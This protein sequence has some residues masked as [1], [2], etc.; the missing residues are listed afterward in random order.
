MRRTQSVT[1]TGAQAVPGPV[2]RVEEAC[3]R[4]PGRWL[5]PGPPLADPPLR[6]LSLQTAYLARLERWCQRR[7][8][9]LRH[10]ALVRRQAVQVA[11]RTRAAGSGQQ[12]SAC[13]AFVFALRAV[14]CGHL[15]D[16]GWRSA[17]RTHLPTTLHAAAGCGHPKDSC[18]AFSSSAHARASCRQSRQ[19]VRL[20]H[21]PALGRSQRQVFEF[22][23]RD[24]VKYHC[25]AP[26]A[27]EAACTR[28]SL[29]A[30]PRIKFSSACRPP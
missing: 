20:G 3:G 25:G 17:G 26:E 6:L 7:G 29:T 18:S 24:W 12:A 22:C 13:S 15:I 4:W 19:Q 27:S 23:V 5:T 11:Y 21:G 16:S 9:P 2:P 1:G 28:V 30:P 10:R 14:V 8:Y